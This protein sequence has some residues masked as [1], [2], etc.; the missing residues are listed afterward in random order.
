M[1]VSLKDGK[2]SS[3]RHKTTFFV[4]FR[5]NQPY[6]PSKEKRKQSYFMLSVNVAFLKGD[7][8]EDII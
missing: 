8:R 2:A 7:L 1:S 3:R 5:R 6:F 4:P